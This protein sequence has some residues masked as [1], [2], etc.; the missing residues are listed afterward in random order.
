MRKTKFALAVVAAASLVTAPVI[1]QA[2]TAQRAADTSEEES[3]A[4]IP[5]PVLLIGSLAIIGGIVAAATSG[6]DLPTSP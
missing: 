2:T 5:L 6:D 4:G 1:A 3:F